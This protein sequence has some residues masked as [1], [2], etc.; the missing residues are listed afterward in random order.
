MVNFFSSFKLTH[1]ASNLSCFYSCGFNLDP[2]SPTTLFLLPASSSHPI[3]SASS[4]QPPRP[5]PPKKKDSTILE[6]L[7]SSGEVG[8]PEE[9]GGGQ[10]LRGKE[11]QAGEGQ[12]G[13]SL[14]GDIQEETAGSYHQSDGWLF[15]FLLVACFILTA[16][17][18]L[19][20]LFGFLFHYY[21]LSFNRLTVP[22]VKVP[23]AACS[24]RQ[25]L[26]L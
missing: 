17:V 3:Q 22:Y 1:F 16:A 9:G 24:I 6:F 23:L 4:L 21:S 26:V 18:D 2:D 5:P 19:I 14:R 25:E 20:V 11:G 10:G 7:C 12:S 15:H 8:L 13:Q